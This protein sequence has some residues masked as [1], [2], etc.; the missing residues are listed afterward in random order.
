MVFIC[1][2]CT[3][4]CIKETSILLLLQH[5]QEYHV[6]LDHQVLLFS[7]AG[8]GFLENQEDHGGQ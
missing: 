5:S 3:K 8:Q 6:D 7:Q 1:S 2:S 4:L